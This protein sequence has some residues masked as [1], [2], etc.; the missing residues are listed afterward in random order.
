MI[1]GG[2][3]DAQRNSRNRTTKALR[4]IE[5]KAK[6]L[7]KWQGSINNSHPIVDKRCSISWP[8]VI[9]PN[10]DALILAVPAHTINN[11]LWA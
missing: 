10:T 11:E 8:L 6:H 4:F 2:E 1:G 9:L 5:K 3:A 7:S